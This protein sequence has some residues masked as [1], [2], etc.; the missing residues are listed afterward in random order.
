MKVVRKIWTNDHNSSKI[1]SFKSALTYR[2]EE[3]WQWTDD[4]K[5]CNLWVIDASCDYVPVPEKIYNALSRPPKVAVIDNS[6]E[7]HV[8]PSDWKPFSTPLSLSTIFAW[9]D[10]NLYADTATTKTRRR[11]LD[12]E[13]PWKNHAFKLL[14]WPNVSRYGHKARVAITCS[15]LLNDF[16]DFDTALQWGLPEE[17][18]NQILED[19]YQNSVLNIRVE[20]NDHKQPT[21]KDNNLPVNTN[22]SLIQK[23]LNRFL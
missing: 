7:G 19:C 2:K 11:G 10:E 23:L 14:R 18:L 12:E 16:Y 3:E 22:T 17:T 13:E 9:L 21:K 15:N 6:I 20:N 1:K 5:D 8:F 4:P